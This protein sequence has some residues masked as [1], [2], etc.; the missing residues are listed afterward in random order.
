MWFH[1]REE[2]EGLWHKS[3]CSK[4]IFDFILRDI[5]SANKQQVHHEPDCAPSR[6][7]SSSYGILER[8]SV[9]DGG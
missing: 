6:F 8:W 2:F 3:G 7:E 4:C 1:L 9:D 5:G